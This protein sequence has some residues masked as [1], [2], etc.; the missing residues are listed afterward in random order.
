MSEEKSHIIYTAA[1]IQKYFAK[2]LSAA[3]MYALEKAALDDPFLA[4]AMEGYEAMGEN[5]VDP[6]LAVLKNNFQAQ[7]NAKVVP[8]STVKRF[9]MW[10]VAAAVLV[11]CSGIAITFLFTGNNDGTNNNALA[12]T[13]AVQDTVN[14]FSA[15]SDIPDTGTKVTMDIASGEPVKSPD[16]NLIAQTNPVP[17]MDSNFVYRPGAPEIKNEKDIAGGGYK[18][19][20]QKNNND[21]SSANIAAPA[22]LNNTEKNEALTK[23]PAAETVVTGYGTARK[24]TAISTNEFIAQVVAPDNTPLPFANIKVTNNNEATYADVKGNFILKS[25]EL[26]LNISIKSVGYVAR[27]YTLKSGDKNQKIILAEDELALKDKTFITG[28]AKASSPY[29]NAGRKPFF[30]QP[31]SSLMDVEPEDGWDDYDTYI[32]NNLS[33]PTN[34]LQQKVHGEVQVSFDV[35]NNGT[36]TNVKIAKS[37]CS[38]FDKEVLRLLKEGPQWKAKK[39]KTNTGTLKVKF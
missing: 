26:F 15:Q 12:K 37:L 13:E 1:D 18:N 7:Q 31:D 35:M 38:D 29:K 23:S 30:V 6:Y 28:K 16:K 9:T 4:E 20:E 24:T 2:Q 32:S 21:I 36:V 22:T 14:T 25:P 5:D 10:K 27:N 17:V 8:L 33:L 3:E 11:I 19:D 39:G 34:A